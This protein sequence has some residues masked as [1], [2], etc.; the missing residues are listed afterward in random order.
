MYFF[1][2]D[3]KFKEENTLF[4][5]DLKSEE[6]EERSHQDGQRQYCECCQKEIDFL[7]DYCVECRRS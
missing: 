4:G 2:E 6:K 1:E 5:V 7:Y 3:D